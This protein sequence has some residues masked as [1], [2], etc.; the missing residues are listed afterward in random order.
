MVQ[1]AGGS[2]N[3]DADRMNSPGGDQTNTLIF[4]MLPLLILI[5]LGWVAAARSVSCMLQL[6]ELTQC[7]SIIFSGLSVYILEKRK[8]GDQHRISMPN[9][10]LYHGVSF[11][12][13]TC[14]FVAFLVMTFVCL[15][16]Y[17]PRADSTF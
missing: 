2:F 11:V 14:I 8:G 1:V 13:P 16:E 10:Y 4:Y 17:E 6:T 3:A 5:Y 12:F 9:S 7:V 15:C